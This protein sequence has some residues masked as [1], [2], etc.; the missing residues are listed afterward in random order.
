MV[1]NNVF[2]HSRIHTVVV[3]ALTT[4]LDLEKAPGNIRLSKGEANL[5]RESVVN[6]SQLVT[7][8]KRH[9]SEKIGKVTHG[10]LLEIIDGLHLLFSPREI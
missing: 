2:N 1:Q 5:P 9:L 7:I 6:V 4:N 8:D 10:R 3:C